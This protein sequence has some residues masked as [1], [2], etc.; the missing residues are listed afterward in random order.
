[1]FILLICC[2]RFQLW[3]IS[4]PSISYIAQS[5]FLHVAQSRK[6]FALDACARL[7]TLCGFSE[8]AA[9]I[10]HALAKTCDLPLPDIWT[11]ILLWHLTD[12]LLGSQ[13]PKDWLISCLCW[14]FAFSL[15]L[16]CTRKGKGSCILI[17]WL[18]TSRQ[19]FQA[20]LGVET[21]LI[22]PSA[23]IR[24]YDWTHRRYQLQLCWRWRKIADALKPWRMK[25]KITWYPTSLG[26][27]VMILHDWH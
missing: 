3:N 9:W 18:Y 4:H 13:K 17:D 25:V 5:L 20:T 22:H 12:L 24:H 21:A 8:W 26:W 10:Y 27:C 2:S 1:M 7:K 6:C 19:L 15:G 23:V 11:G 16:C 14:K